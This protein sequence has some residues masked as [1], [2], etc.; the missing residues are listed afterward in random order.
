MCDYFL[1]PDSFQ[2]CSCYCFHQVPE[3]ISSIRQVSKAALKE[4]AKGKW[5]GEEAF[6]NSQKF[7]VL[8][9]G[10]VTVPHKKVPSTLI[11][12]CIHKLQHKVE[13]KDVG[14]TESQC[15]SVDSCVQFVVGD[16][17]VG[18]GEEDTKDA[19]P[20]EEGMAGEQN[21]FG[22]PNLGGLQEAF[23]QCLLDDRGPGAQ[24]E[25]RVR[26]NSLKPKEGGSDSPIRRRHGSAPSRVQPSD[27]DKNC[28]M[29]FQV[30]LHSSAIISHGVQ[31]K[32]TGLCC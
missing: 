29:L 4:D 30:L 10:K 3:V 32:Y 12:D 23:P 18:S 20:A 16:D 26:C 24:R 22:S 25:F 19:R 31:S 1:P 13:Q 9:R 11:D 17:G 8:Y 15:D 28:T 21:L 5:N 2:S 27:T 7:E 14:L 6:Y